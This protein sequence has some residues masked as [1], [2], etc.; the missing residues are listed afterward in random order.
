VTGTAI[1]GCHMQKPDNIDFAKLL[2]FEMLT[3]EP[4]EEL[5]FQDETLAARLGAK[6][7]E[8]EILEPEKR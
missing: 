1:L 5:D 3:L 6:V 4:S 8:P 2:G 7:G